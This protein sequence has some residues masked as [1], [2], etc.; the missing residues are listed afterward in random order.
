M[1]APMELTP[2]QQFEIERISRAIDA[3]VDPQQLRKIAKQL[4]QAWHIQKAA[5]HW[6]IHQQ[7]GPPAAAPSGPDVRS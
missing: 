3:T 7:G 5:T 1:V 4:L 2:A 6:W